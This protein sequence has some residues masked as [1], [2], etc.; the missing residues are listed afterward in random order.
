MTKYLQIRHWDYWRS[1]YGYARNPVSSVEFSITQDRD[2]EQLF[3]H[4][5]MDTL[6]ALEKLLKSGEYID[7]NDASYQYF[8]GRA[9]KLRQGS[10]DY[11]VGALYYKDYTPDMVKCNQYQQAGKDIFSVKSP[12]QSPYY[13]WLF[14]REERP[15]FPELL[16]EW[17][18]RLSPSLFCEQ[19]TYEI[20]NVPS[21]ED[22]AEACDIYA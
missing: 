18:E 10:M 14:I 3:F 2:G 12:Q 4:L 7:K 6:P 11:F 22:T 13:A 19:F 15:L 17:M 1:V 20:A 16:A 8:L 9:E 21:R 5:D